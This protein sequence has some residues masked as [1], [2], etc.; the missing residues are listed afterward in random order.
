MQE[1]L[2]SWTGSHKK[3][4]KSIDVWIDGL[5]GPVN[6]G[7]TACIGYVIKNGGVTIVEGAYVVGK[8]VEMTNNVAE[9]TA[10]IYALKEIKRLGLENKFLTI[11]SDSQLLVNQ[12]NRKWAVKAPLIV[13]LYKLA[14][15][16]VN[17]LHYRVEWIP[18]EENE[19]ADRLTRLAYERSLL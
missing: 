5:C 1:A 17:R 8:G 6:P 14:K 19:E 12:M 10:L 16:L 11:R 3:E 13:S 9:Y 2:T 4:E 7:G 15:D 18:R